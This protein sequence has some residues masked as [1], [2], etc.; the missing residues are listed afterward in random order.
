M[1]FTGTA[2]AEPESVTHNSRRYDCIVNVGD[3]RL[4]FPHPGL[5][6][7][8]VDLPT[9]EDTLTGVYVDD[10]QTIL[11]QATATGRHG[12]HITLTVLQRENATDHFGDLEVEEFGF[13]AYASTTDM[14][15]EDMVSIIW[16]DYIDPQTDKHLVVAIETD[17]RYFENNGEEFMR[18]AASLH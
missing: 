11:Y 2:K 4:T 8:Q 9:L 17:S 6:F 5:D 13:I 7:A 15:G 3:Y 12:N 1:V 16:V 18:I 10:D 14:V